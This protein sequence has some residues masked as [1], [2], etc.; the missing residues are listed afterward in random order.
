MD[1]GAKHNPVTVEGA[2]VQEGGEKSQKE[3]ARFGPW[4]VVQRNSRRP[5]KPV[6]SKN[7]IAQTPVSARNT[8]GSTGKIRFK[9]TATDKEGNQRNSKSAD[10]AA[11]SS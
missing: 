11:S 4:T 6:K 2:G 8:G 5:A 3:A 10:R 1:E 7:E 9:K